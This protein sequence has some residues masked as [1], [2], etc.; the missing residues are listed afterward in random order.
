MNFWSFSINRPVL[1]IVLSL[2][3][4]LFGFIGF[5][6]LGVREFPSVDPPIITV[7]TTYTGANA[8]VIETQ[9]TEPLESSINGIAGIRSISSV[10]SDGRSNITVEFNLGT[11]LEAAANDVRDRVSRAIRSLPPDCDPPT[12]VKSDA[13]AS[14]IIS[15]TIQS[16]TRTLLD[17]S[18][19]ANNQ[20]KERL[21]TVPG[22]SEVRVW[23][24]K[25]YA[26]RIQIDPQKLASY[27]L[28]PSD[29][30]DAINRESIE[31]PSGR[32]EGYS[33][34]LT[35]RTLGRLDKPEQFNNLIIK[36]GNGAVVRLRD[37]GN[38]VFAPE[39]ERTI[40]RG[41]GDIPMVG[42]AVTPQPGSNYIDIADEVTKRVEQ[43]K[44]DLPADITVSLA[45]DITRTIRKSIKEVEETILI[46]FGLVVLVIFIF[47]R[48]WRTT[49]I[50]V[51][52]IPISL[53][54]AFFIM[55]IAGFSINILTLLAIVLATGL[56]V[57][58]AIVVLENIY[59]KIES[60]MDPMEAGHKG[61]KEIFFAIVSTTITLAAVFLPIIFLQGMT[62]RL[63]RE[64][65]IVVAGSV[66]ISAFISLTLTPMMSARLIRKS[67]KQ[68][69]FFDRTEEIINNM[70]EAYNRSLKWFIPRRW[71]AFVIMG[72]S[73]VII[74]LVGS[75]VPSEL[76]PMEDKGRLTVNAIAPE[77][78]SF[79]NMD[80]YVE[81][82]IRMTD[83]IDGKEA[84]IAVTA[85]GF[86]SA[87]SVNSGFVRVMLNDPSQ[88]S[89]TQQQIADNLTSKFRGM[90]FARTFVTQDQTIG[91]SGGLPVQFVIQATDLDKLKEFL[92]KFME[93]ANADT[94]FQTVDLNL[95]FNKPEMTIEIDRDKARTLGVS[96][97]SIAEALQ[98]LFSGQRY[99]FF[100]KDSKQY[101]VIGQVEREFRDQP[102]HLTSIYLKNSRGEL[103]QLDNVVKV[104]YRSSPP[105]LYRYNRY[106]SATVSA[107]PAPG[108]TLGQAID[109]MQ[110]IAKTTLDDTFTTSLEGT[111]KEFK[112]SS[113][114]LYFAFLLALIIVFLILAAQFESFASPLVIMFTVPLALA[115]AVLTLWIFGQTLNIFSQIGIIVLVGIVTK[116]GILI[117]EFAN[118]RRTQGLPV[119]E[120]V[121]DAATRRLRPI[122]MTSFATMLGALP[123]ALALGAAAKSRVP[124][125]IAI[126]GGLFFSLLLTLYVIPAL[127]TYFS[128]DRS[129]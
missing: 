30:R 55:Y 23:G 112:D 10:S 99:G 51:I 52:A 53:I 4:L 100:I 116:N 46:A 119:R 7:T 26:I 118:Q 2:M 96:V 39:N 48:N 63:F 37:I 66:I 115:G 76:A 19:I 75:R 74:F 105:Q 114:T 70:I 20:F 6:F 125:G 65:G 35:I 68:H 50:P 59:H 1:T 42:V 27:G 129:K 47:L 8:D 111:S 40:L 101:Y 34:E 82:L 54:G 25:R 15:Y 78:T 73:V 60:G 49:L 28:S 58:D 85:P 33:T 41:N 69:K 32:I 89:Q 16:N 29:V 21:Q 44:K 104:T 36:E 84:I 12:V 43:I 77:G 9:I 22:V 108:V 110:K 123:I 87:S 80:A 45:M 124:M 71:L 95:K 24:E 86:G 120:A 122:L 88:R 67:E 79:E 113:N 17:L 91:R 106:V 98:L 18:D 11:D 5:S 126:I 14:P 127:Y 56:V 94:T 121:I 72:V 62:G 81:K 38:A 90:S 97:R 64:F 93:K 31:L 128:K 107:A 103:I 13:D 92:P 61:L 109:E 102:G 83:T 57:D 3:V 117:V